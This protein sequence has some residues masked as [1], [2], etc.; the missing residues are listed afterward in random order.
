MISSWEDLRRNIRKGTLVFNLFFFSPDMFSTTNTVNAHLDI[1]DRKK[2]NSVA[3][4]NVEEF[5]SK[6]KIFLFVS[7]LFAFLFW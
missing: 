5:Y 6:K 1:S 3:I 7:I 4:F 2:N